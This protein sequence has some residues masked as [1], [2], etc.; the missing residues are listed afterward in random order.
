[1]FREADREGPGGP[2]ADGGTCRVEQGGSESE[3]LCRLPGLQ[4][5]RAQGGRLVVLRSLLLP[6]ETPLVLRSV[7]AESGAVLP[8]V[9]AAGA[10]REPGGGTEVG[11]R[12]A[13]ALCPATS[14]KRR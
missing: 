6:A 10:A 13:R 8:A 11:T 1:M 5:T 2:E 4:R 7:A 12:R 3:G 9:R 14:A